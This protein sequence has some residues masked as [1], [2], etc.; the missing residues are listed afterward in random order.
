MV[1]RGLVLVNF[2][3]VTAVTLLLVAGHG[4]WAG[5]EIWKITETHGLNSG[6][7]LPIGTWAVSAWCCVALWIRV[8]LHDADGGR[9]ST[10]DDR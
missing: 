3:A 5:H 6:D 4:P 2:A 7:L 1:S 9:D 10:D 8:G